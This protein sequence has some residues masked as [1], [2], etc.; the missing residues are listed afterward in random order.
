R[1]YADWRHTRAF[2][3]A[4]RSRPFVAYRSAV[5][6]ALEA[7]A[8][9]GDL[10]VRA[11][12]AASGN[13][14][15]GHANVQRRLAQMKRRLSRRQAE[16]DGAAEAP[17][18]ASTFRG[19][20][21]ARWL[22][23]FLQY[24]RCLALDGDAEG[25]L[26]VLDSVFGSNMFAGQQGERRTV[27]L[28][29]LAIAISSGV[30]HRLYDLV[31][32][33]C[34][35]QPNKAAAYKILGYAMAGSVEAAMTLTSAGMYKYV[36]RQLSELNEIYY[37]RGHAVQPP[38][39]AAIDTPLEAGTET[40]ASLSRVRVMGR[41]D[42][43][44]SDVSAVHSVAAHV[45]LV[46]RTGYSSIMQ[47]TLALAL[48]PQDASIALHL[49]VAYLQHAVR[50]GIRDARDMVVRSLAYL[51]RYAELQYAAEMRARGEQVAQVHMEGELVDVVVTQEI[52][53][54]MAR[55]FHF[56]GMLD[57][58]S[59]HYM[60]V[61]SLPVSR[62]AAAAD[63]AVLCPTMSDLRREA[64]Y[65]LASICVASGAVVQAQ[66]LLQKYCTI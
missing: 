48:L 56:L 51:Q 29:M 15:G 20:P 62:L 3:K 46:A 66:R 32:W 26:D 5:M 9:A 11:A 63:D 14:D 8:A 39:P 30:Q 22:D 1:L 42:L 21:F 43:S 35:S 24:A 41:R 57:L 50:K 6:A 13:D 17:S 58:A 10:D 60:R 12:A 61:F 25:A 28:V 36:R 55:V 34:G 31:R 19:Q 37:A 40:V 59:D 18:A 54:N 33:W 38:V 7:A 65:N 16:G 2:F 47:Y 52:A 44:R 53:Y 49:S 23:M 64:A 45:M 27:R 4:D